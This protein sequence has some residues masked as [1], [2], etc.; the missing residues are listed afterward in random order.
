MALAAILRSAQD[1]SFS[2]L[3]ISG[4]KLLVACTRSVMSNTEK[5]RNHAS[6]P[7][8]CRVLC[9]ISYL[10]SMQQE[11]LDEKLILPPSLCLSLCPFPSLSVFLSIRASVYFPCVFSLVY[12][13]LSF[14]VSEAKV[15]IRAFVH[16]YGPLTQFQK[17]RVGDHS[18]AG[19][20]PD[21]KHVR[22]RDVNYT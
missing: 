14:S 4:S 10:Q 9:A 18:S 22:A 13:L 21:V 15:T 8:T 20:L 1:A 17:F 2:S 6:T 11:R 5:K 12:L 7:V 19:F 16:A 3:T